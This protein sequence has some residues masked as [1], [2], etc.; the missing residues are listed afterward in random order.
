MSPKG[1]KLGFYQFGLEPHWKLLPALNGATWLLFSATF[2]G[3]GSGTLTR[4]AILR[5]EENRFINLLPD[6]ALTNQSDEAIWNE[7]ALSPYPL[8][9]AADFIWDFDAGE[10]HFS[11][12]RFA[13]EAWRFD[14]SQDRYV[15]AFSYKT[16]KKYLGLDES[17]SANVI[18]PERAEILRRLVALQHHP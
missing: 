15:L 10:T 4:Y 12:H 9:I 5:P 18:K 17:D 14:I 8:L 7:P 11:R 16:M 1:E 2:S 6:F 13:V 3:G